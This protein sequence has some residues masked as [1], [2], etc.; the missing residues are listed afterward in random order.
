MFVLLMQ[1]CCMFSQTYQEPSI[2]SNIQRLLGGNC[3]YNH[4]QHVYQPDK[5]SFSQLPI[6]FSMDI[7]FLHTSAET[8]EQSPLSLIPAFI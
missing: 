8:N 1:N 4:L 7:S 6:I 3:K 2:S 5:I